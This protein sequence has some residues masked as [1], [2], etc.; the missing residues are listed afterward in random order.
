MH[1][2]SDRAFERHVNRLAGVEAPERFPAAV[3]GAEEAERAGAPVEWRSC[4]PAPEEILKAVHAPGYLDRVDRLSVEGGGYLDLDTGLNEHSWEAATLASGAA[5]GAVDSSLSGTAAFSIARPPGHHAGRNYGMGFCLLNH[6]AVA[7]EH[8]RS[9]GIERIAILDWDVHHGNGTQ[10]IFYADGE[11]LYLS[12][13]QSPFYPGT[14]DV[15]EV[16]QKEGR[17]FTVNVPLRA[18]S[19]EDIYAAAFAGVFVPVLRE[20][21]PELLIISAGYDAHTADLIGGMQL[22][23]TSFG[24]FAARLAAVAREIEAV[25]LALLLEGGYN[26]RALT[27]SVAATIQGVEEEPSSEW[28]YLGD[29]RSVEASRKVLAPFWESLR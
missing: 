25:P 26:L 29:V 11:V 1:V 10:D 24:R 8:A 23:A 4:Q 14:G 6:A 2:Y 20:F 12:A 28:E 16:G 27:E 21:R 17:G 3:A 22:E 19:G 13:H 18:R 7:A 9:R 5:I 15:H